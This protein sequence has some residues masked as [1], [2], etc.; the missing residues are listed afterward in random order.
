MVKIRK[1][2]VADEHGAPKEVII[3]WKQFCEIAETLRF[4]LDEPARADLRTARRDF[5]Q[6]KTAAF[7]P[8]AEI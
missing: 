5:R 7:L 4:D 1:K 3:P 8:L 6:G 2:I